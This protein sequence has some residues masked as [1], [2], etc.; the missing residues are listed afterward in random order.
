[1]LNEKTIYSNLTIYEAVDEVYKGAVLQV[2]LKTT[3]ALSLLIFNPMLTKLS[4]W[5]W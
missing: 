4:H 2:H 5:M 1:M 3:F